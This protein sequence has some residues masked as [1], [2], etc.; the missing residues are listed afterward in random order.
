MKSPQVSISDIAREFGVSPSTVSRALKNH[1]EISEATCRRIQEYARKVNYRPNV[2]ALGLKQQKSFTIGVV[3]PEI[4]H[5]FFSSVISGIEEVAYGQG[6]RVIICQ[7]NE[8]YHR[9][10]INVAALTDHRVDGI[11]LSIS[12]STRDHA[13]LR[14]L[15]EQEIPVVFMDRAS[16]EID[17]DRV[18]TNDFEGARM[19]VS[20]L[21][22]TGRRNIIHL[23]GPQHLCVGRERYRGYV[24]ALQEHGVEER[25]EW[26]LKCDTP[27]R[28]KQL[29][30]KLLSLI[31]EA[32]AIFAVNDFTA[33]AAMRLLQDHGYEVP[34]QIAVAGF[35]DDPIASVVHPALTTVEQRGYDIGKEAARMLIQRLSGEPAKEFRTKVFPAFLKVRASG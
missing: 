4:V 11:L 22:K 32:D 13:H 27:A 7:S 30:S 33:V 34:G 35:G 26:V 20:H 3:I 23:A 8:D 25:E 10:V 31:T 28:V 6:Y 21:L 2:I 1:P 16:P 19:V 9:E 24:E 17:S 5:H 12:K 15:V 29:G 18:L 14:R